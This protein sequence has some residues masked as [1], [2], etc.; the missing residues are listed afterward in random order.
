MFLEKFLFLQAT[1]PME[2]TRTLSMTPQLM[3]NRLL[4]DSLF[5][6]VAWVGLTVYKCPAAELP[7][8][9][10]LPS[11]LNRAVQNRTGVRQV[12]L[13]SESTLPPAFAVVPVNRVSVPNAS[14]AEVKVA[15]SSGSKSVRSYPSESALPPGGTTLVQVKQ[16]EVPGSPP[17]KN[18]S[19]LQS[20]TTEQP[21][22]K[23]VQKD[24]SDRGLVEESLFKQE[25]ETTPWPRII[26]DG[27]IS[28]IS[29][30]AFSPDGR[31][32]YSA[33]LDKLIHVWTLD[34]Q[35]QWSHRDVARWQVGRGDG[36]A[37]NSVLASE[38]FLFVGGYG[39]KA[40]REI[41]LF[42]R[43]TLQTLSPLVDP[44]DL[45]APSTDSLADASSDEKT[46]VLATDLKGGVVRWELDKAGLWNA[47]KLRDRSD[48][49]LK[50]SP[51]V[52]L[53][54][55]RVVVPSLS[56]RPA[57]RPW[58]LEVLSSI[59]GEIIER[60][61]Q[62]LAGQ[63]PDR[64]FAAMFETIEKSL[65]KK[66]SSADK[67]K[68]STDFLSSTFSGSTCTR[69]AVSPGG[70]FVVSLDDEGWLVGW[71]I[72]KGL[73]LKYRQVEKLQNLPRFEFISLAWS[74]QEQSFFVAEVDKKFRKCRIQKWT[75]SANGEWKMSQVSDELDKNVLTMS[76][77]GGWLAHDSGPQLIVRKTSD[78]SLV[79]DLG[80]NSFYAP[81]QIQWAAGGSI[82][83]RWSDLT[84]T[85]HAMGIDTNDRGEKRLQLTD[86]SKGQWL[87]EPT[88]AGGSLPKIDVDGSLAVTLPNIGRATLEMDL[89]NGETIVS[90]YGNLTSTTWILND[91]GQPTGVATSFSDASHIRVHGFPEAGTRVC[92][93]K[94][95]FRGHED[96]TN[97]MQCS[98][99]GRFLISSGQDRRIC[100]WPLNGWDA[101]AKPEFEPLA[102]WGL[103]SNTKENG[104]EVE[105]VASDGPLYSRGLR[106]GDR[107]VKLAWTELDAATSKWVSKSTEV[108]EEI[109]GRLQSPASFFTAYAFWYQRGLDNVANPPGFRRNC[110]WEP[111][112]TVAMNTQREWAAWT[113][114]GFY[115]ASINGDRLFGWQLNR[116][117]D[118]RPEFVPADRFRLALE[119][120]DLIGN[121]LESGNIANAFEKVAIQIPG[122]PDGL[123]T[124]FL[125][126]QPSIEIVSPKVT[127][128][129]QGN[130]TRLQAKVRVTN[131]QTIGSPQAFVNGVIATNFRT[132]GN[133][134]GAIDPSD[135]S[136]RVFTYEWDAMLPSDPKLK[137][138]VYAS[139]QERHIGVGEVVL[140]RIPS[141]LKKPSAAPLPNVYVLAAGVSEYRD[142]TLSLSRASD[143]ATEMAEV[144]ANN[145]IRQMTSRVSVLIDSMV[146]PAAWRA[147]VESLAERLA[148]RVS[149]DDLVLIYLTG[150]GVIDPTTKEYHFVTS[151]A[152]M[153]DVMAA[154]YE[155]CISL[156]DLSSLKQ[157]ACKKL[158]IL[159][160][161]H[162]GAAQ[163]LAPSQLKYAVRNL[164]D[165]KMFVMTASE[166]DQLAFEGAFSQPLIKALEGDADF[167]RNRIVSIR[168]VFDYIRT[169][170]RKQSQSQF[171]TLGP[172]DLIDLVNFPIVRSGRTEK[173]TGHKQ[174]PATKLNPQIYF[175][176]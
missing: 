55:N 103:R 174:I 57:D 88:V 38:R 138:Q 47:K 61:S 23:N 29:T 67:A 144:L 153:R 171:P 83:W 74:E 44:A 73:V 77:R 95:V 26:Q 62:Q 164:Q 24:A 126:L 101:A 107:I 112:L 52:A 156:S 42:D 128:R 166:G 100:V 37:I 173:L 160:T 13:P 139:T 68:F 7:S 63:T 98:K 31:F 15:E 21:P 106:V 64:V 46:V 129:I 59:T 108:S 121:L 141:D 93:L 151:R 53:P 110:Q 72:G 36:G 145:S 58:E 22:Q 163:Q 35:N 142:P 175:S 148:G 118:I 132:V 39:I 60:L 176:R 65:N 130:R 43:N 157:V 161:C 54:S 105:G 76:V 16:P 97:A 134:S 71:E 124:R 125:A 169:S 133:T 159:D 79:A 137:V 154:R 85:Q 19:K 6:I 99:D 143:N 11:Y 90:R 5:L 135:A 162:S 123:L 92:P 140:E 122:G 165:D 113:P 2:R 50:K 70:K 94:R 49:R 33:G 117:P 168:E 40:E 28:T 10:A 89:K 91:A 170:M 114:L 4:I 14:I 155:D 12:V 32:L 69:M 78:L 75:V 120:P 115:D 158:V 149:P 86:G 3:K 27:H 116:G 51:I 127:D 96:A 56:K 146:T 25:G 48:A 152:S 17:T 136:K 45:S 30:I 66:L 18:D 80:R 111:L 8:E 131:G 150:H 172:V 82:G 9:N 119:R 84:N 109:L 1:Y 167:D 20:N 41:G 147:S 102:R 81:K 104:I 34:N 87:S